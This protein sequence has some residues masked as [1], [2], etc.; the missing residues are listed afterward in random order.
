MYSYELEA[1]YTWKY[2][3][4]LLVWDKYLYLKFLSYENSTL[5]PNRIT[6]LND[7]IKRTF[8]DA[9]NDF[10]DKFKRQFDWENKQTL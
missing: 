9:H 5:R 2:L 10:I 8:V 6:L 4:G 3:I 7:N 1:L